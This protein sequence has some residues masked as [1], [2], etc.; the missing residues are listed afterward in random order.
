MHSEPEDPGADDVPA[1][2]RRIVLGHAGADRAAVL[3]DDLPL[4]EDGLGLDSIAIV[5]VVVECEDRFGVSLKALVERPGIRVGDLIE[6]V[7]RA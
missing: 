1:A 5:E 3:S 7:Q 4:G 6:H 2:V